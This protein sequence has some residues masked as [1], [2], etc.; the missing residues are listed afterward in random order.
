MRNVAAFGDGDNDAAM[1]EAVGVGVA[2]G[3][4][5]PEPKRRASYTTTT[6]NEGGVGKFLSQVYGFELEP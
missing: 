3:N 6:N 4:A 5:M 1:L 2:M